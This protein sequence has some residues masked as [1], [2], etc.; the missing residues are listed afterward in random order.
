MARAI[1]QD[2]AGSCARWI[3]AADGDLSGMERDGEGPSGRALRLGAPRAF[4][5][6]LLHARWTPRG[7]AQLWIDA[8]RSGHPALMDSAWEA[9]F[10][11]EA[12]SPGLLLSVIHELSPAC[13]ESGNA[14]TLARAFGCAGPSGVSESSMKASALLKAIELG[15]GPMVA[16]L[17]DMGAF[18]AFAPTSPGP[19]LRACQAWVQAEELPP[20]SL[21]AH[22]GW[23]L[24]ERLA[25]RDTM[26]ERLEIAR[27][28]IETSESAWPAELASRELAAC[29][30]AL[31]AA[32]PKSHSLSSRELPPMARRAEARSIH[33]VASAPCARQEPPRR[34]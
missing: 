3:K 13:V 19:A 28:L 9:A 14:A 24:K 22:L 31:R 21:P 20:E 32:T 6:L 10:K 16:S 11:A 34:L 33:L 1:E 8:A 7:I 23:S 15:S 25:E 29:S 2:D 18:D 27:Q 12:R 4:Q 30:A 5:A 26:Q 17:L